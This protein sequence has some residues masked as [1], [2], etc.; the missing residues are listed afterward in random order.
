MHNILT[1]G[2]KKNITSIPSFTTR[3]KNNN[4]R[5]SIKQSQNPNRKNTPIF[6]PNR[7]TKNTTTPL[8]LTPKNKTNQQTI[9]QQKQN[10][11]PYIQIYLNLRHF[12]TN[13]N[14]QS[15]QNVICVH[16]RAI[17]SLIPR[18][19]LSQQAARYSPN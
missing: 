1:P 2:I 13:K 15:L 19:S 16:L 4:T 7:R 8:L 10:K 11:K 5:K 12:S 6:H 3:S 14:I 18:L 17:F 9:R